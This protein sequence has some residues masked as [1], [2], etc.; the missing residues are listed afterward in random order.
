MLI[1]S[2]TGVWVKKSEEDGSCVWCL[3]FT[4]GSNALRGERTIE[5]IKAGKRKAIRQTKQ[6]NLAIGTYYN[7][8]TMAKIATDKDQ[9][10]NTT[11]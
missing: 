11:R 4:R 8:A 7:T 2:R 1:E 10:E 9:S 5:Q 3:T 6:T